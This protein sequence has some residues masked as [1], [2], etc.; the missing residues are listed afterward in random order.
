M[1][2]RTALAIVASILIL[3]CSREAKSASHRT[4]VLELFTSQGCSSCPPADKLLSKLGRES[5][6][7]GRIIPLAYHVDYWNHL[8][9]RDPFSSAQWSARQN[10]YA[11]A[12]R[13]AQI[14]TPQVV[15]GGRAQM[16]GSAEVHVR[17][18]IDRQLEQQDR[19]FITIDRVTRNG[20]TL[21]V[22]LHARVVA[23]RA[24]VMVALFENGITTSVASGENAR[25]ELTNDYI[26]RWESRV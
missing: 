5:F 23:G 7:G 22:D 26:V 9:W 20:D 1:P 17:G 11:R 18:E 19:G 16:V 25:R 8:G 12:I 6:D 21:L 14:Y 24:N 15:I 10:E 13:S 4:V 2:T 3:A